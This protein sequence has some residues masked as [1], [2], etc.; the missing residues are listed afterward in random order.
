MKRIAGMFGSIRAV[1]Q[2]HRWIVPTVVATAIVLVGCIVGGR[3]IYQHFHSGA[4]GV[5]S[6]EE[7]GMDPTY[8]EDDSSTSASVSTDQLQTEY[9][10]DS[11][12]VSEIYVS[13]G[14]KVK[15]GDKLFAYDSTL[16]QI[17]LKRKAIEIQKKKIKLKRARKQ[18]AVIKT[19]RAGMPIPG[20]GGSSS[21]SS[22]GSTSETSG[23]SSS[24]GSSGSSSGSSS[25]GGSGSSTPTYKGLDL[26]GGNG[27]AR[28]PYYYAWSSSFTFTKDFIAAAM[29]GKDEAYVMFLLSGSEIPDN[30][31]GETE[32]DKDNAS[33][34]TGGD[35][36]DG[37]ADNKQE[38]GDTQ[39]DTQKDSGNDSQDDA[40]DEDAVSVVATSLRSQTAISETGGNSSSSISKLPDGTQ[41][42]ASW[43]MQ[44]QKSGS[45]YRYVLLSMNVG[46]AER[47]ISSAMTSKPSADDSKKN[48]KKNNKDNNTD[49]KDNNDNDDSDSSTDDDGDNGATY[50]QA[51]INQLLADQVQ[52]VKDLEL[53]IRQGEL[54]Y[55]KLKKECDDS[56]VR[57]TVDGV[58]TVLRSPQKAGTSKPF[59][60]LSGDNA[61]Y[62]ITSYVSEFDLDSVAVGQTVTVTNQDTGETYEGK[63]KSISRY[64]A[65]DVYFSDNPNVSY[66]PYTVAIDSYADFDL[67]SSVSVSYGKQ[68][69]QST[70]SSYYLLKAFV[71]TENGSSYIYIAK[72]DGTLEKRT[73]KT[74]KSYW[75]S[76]VEVIGGVTAQDKV[77][78][79]YGQNVHDGA[80][81]TEGNTEDLYS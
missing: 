39:Q 66:Y 35:S 18:L 65:S 11:E 51:E 29:Q 59:I 72:S 48:D 36:S 61:G 70:E 81:T 16:N 28:R 60:K 8:L 24:G 15:E 22:G 17:S 7:V 64:P 6:V 13:K 67:N 44:F 14:Q 63:V 75:G 52:K 79:P 10:S 40:E 49:K 27:T 41:Y 74:G 50:T 71:R 42:F 4:V 53:A 31:G 12:T 80:Q 20:S 56:V 30:I 26:L 45:G 54:A 1:T 34:S 55:K 62:S 21:G 47:T 76:Y 37:S 25:S 9:L 5:Y 78:F 68:S 38:T 77:A 19:Y 57:A 32:E 46:G 33:N 58:V 3:K 43:T 23:G 2:K 69:E 73:I